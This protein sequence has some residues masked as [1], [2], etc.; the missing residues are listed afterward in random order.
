MIG[1]GAAA[2]YCFLCGLPFSGPHDQRTQLAGVDLEWLN[3]GVGFDPTHDVTIAVEPDDE[4][5]RFPL[6]GRPG[7][8]FCVES[9]YVPSRDDARCKYVGIVCHEDCHSFVEQT[10][11]RDV[12]AR[13]MAEIYHE[14]VHSRDYRGQSFKW[15]MAYDREGPAYFHSPLS[16]VGHQTRARILASVAS[17]TNEVTP[18]E[19]PAVV[20]TR[21]TIPRTASPRF[22]SPRI[23]RPTSSSPRSS[24]H[25][26]KVSGPTSIRT[27]TSRPSANHRLKTPS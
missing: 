7:E 14:S 8:L 10:L 3:G 6:Y 12:Y 9:R 13:T 26:T 11:R 20:T 15:E 17:Y 16:E 21:P 5:G 22:T 1:Y 19:R 24:S 18:T 23:A 4:Y 27:S 25:R 2:E